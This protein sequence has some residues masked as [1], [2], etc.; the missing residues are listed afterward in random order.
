MGAGQEADFSS[1]ADAVAASA[2]GDTILLAR[3]EWDAPG[4][5]DLSLTLQGRC[6]ELVDVMPEFIE[7]AVSE[8]DAGSLTWLM[9]ALGFPDY[10]AE[11]YAY[12][13]VIGTGNVVAGW[14]PG[15]EAD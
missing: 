6:Q 4:E 15:Q 7:Q 11:I 2:D 10:P 5:L 12:G 3:G 1:L 14:F 8:A 13:T 9:S